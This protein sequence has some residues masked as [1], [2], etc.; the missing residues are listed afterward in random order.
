MRCRIK[1][2]CRDCLVL[3]MAVQIVNLSID[4]VGFY[5]SLVD[6]T[7]VHHWDYDDSMI[8][9]FVENILGCP[10]TTF[11]DQANNNNTSKQQQNILH[12]DLKCNHLIAFSDFFQ[13]QKKVANFI[14][15]NEKA[16]ILYNQEVLPKPPQHLSV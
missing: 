11:H 8:E 15:D 14:P 2:I 3:L 10:S 9:Y 4:S 6:T 13:I 16:V 12:L 5:C 7:S 1:N